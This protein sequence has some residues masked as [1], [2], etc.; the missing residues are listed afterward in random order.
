MKPS[1][2]LLIYSLTMYDETN[3]GGEHGRIYRVL[4]V[5]TR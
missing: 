2:D 5:V 3:N 4:N 1:S